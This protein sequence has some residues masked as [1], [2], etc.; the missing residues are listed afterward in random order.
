MGVVKPS[1]LFGLIFSSFKNG[2]KVR[3]INLIDKTLGKKKKEATLELSHFAPFF[4]VFMNN[5]NTSTNFSR[6]WK[7]LHGRLAHCAAYT[8]LFVLP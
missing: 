7:L 8:Q 5:K 6:V 1:Q 3:K 2:C 4:S